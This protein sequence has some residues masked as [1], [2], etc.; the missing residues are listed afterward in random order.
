M[1]D[2]FP[3]WRGG[4]AVKIDGFYALKIGKARWY[5]NVE[6][7]EALTKADPEEYEL[8][9]GADNASTMSHGEDRQF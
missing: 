9:I 2:S 6:T 4:A 1:L 8:I 3:G 7:L 5:S